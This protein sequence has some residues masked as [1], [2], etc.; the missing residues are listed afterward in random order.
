M[1]T[2]SKRISGGG[3]CLTDKFVSAIGAKSVGKK[4]LSRWEPIFCFDGGDYLCLC[5]GKIYV[6]CSSKSVANNK[7]TADARVYFLMNKV[8]ALQA[9]V[10]IEESVA[11]VHTSRYLTE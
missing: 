1:I 11:D 2:R 3:A 6:K 5:Y 7:A 4:M 10:T 8:A 9:I